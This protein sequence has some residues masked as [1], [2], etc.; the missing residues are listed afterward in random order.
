MRSRSMLTQLR[1]PALFRVEDEGY[2]VGKRNHDDGV[3]VVWWRRE[4]LP[5]ISHRVVEITGDN[6]LGDATSQHDLVNCRREV[7]VV[8]QLQES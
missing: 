3:L 5:C 7:V 1:R 8:G 2:A 4:F 6:L